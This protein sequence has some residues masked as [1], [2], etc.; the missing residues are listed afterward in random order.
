MKP[1]ALLRP[2]LSSLLLALVLPA[3][4]APPSATEP[5]LPTSFLARQETIAEVSQAR[6]VHRRGTAGFEIIGDGREAFLARLAAIEAAQKS[7]DLQY[8]IWADDVTG[9]VI[10][11]RLLA[12]ADRG[13]KVRLLLDITKGAQEEV[14][15]SRLAAHPNVE[16]GFF[17]PMFDLKGIFAG[18][19]LPVIGELDRMQSRM[20]N[21]MLIA[22]GSLM[23]GGGRN[24][25]DTYFGVDRRH[26]MRDLDFIATGP[27]VKDALKSFNLYWE[28]PL[29]RRGDRS[30]LTEK[31]QERLRDLR[32]DLEDKK[33]WMA[34][35]NRCPY[36]VSL[37]R[38]EA[39]DILRGFSRRLIWAEYEFIADPPERMLRQGKEASP[40]WRT[41]EGAIRS[42]RREVVMHAAYLIPQD[43]TLKLFE[44]TTRRGVTV[45]LLTNSFA[46]IDG[47]MA[48]SGI[49]GRRA[50]VLKTGSRLYELNA[51]A[52]VREKY[53]HAPKPTP[54]GMHSKGMVVDGRVSFIGS[55]NMDPRSKYI[56]TET[57]VIIRSPAF[58]S[59]L[60]NYLMEDLRPEN[61]WHV[62]QDEKGRF[63]WTCERPGQPPVVHHT[64]PD[65]PWTKRL[66]FWLVTHLPVEDL[67]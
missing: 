12:A 48:M 1:P 45:T 27:V 46:S 61:C 39:L 13:V 20:H 17:N 65:V 23:I 29:T 5:K 47:L 60:K 6:T 11:T 38:G 25:G 30:R 31:D 63:C 40:V 54:L 32:E 3:C 56:N 22:D 51:Q 57:G 67:L 43:E 15:S 37:T 64:D 50:D 28:S 55:Y 62:T 7:L 35:K 9:T 14:R 59:R 8:F 18:N 19:P 53:I 36:P 42:A 52:P 10:A 16:T 34:R 66:R 33:R 2:S 58:A 44:E 21:K 49:A 26:N 4:V 41:K 24:L